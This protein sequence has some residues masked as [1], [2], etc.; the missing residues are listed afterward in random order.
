[1]SYPDSLIPL[2]A[3]LSVRPDTLRLL[4]EMAQEMNATI[5]EVLSAIAED[6]VADLEPPKLGQD[7]VIPFQCSTADL[8]AVQHRAARDSS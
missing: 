2:Q 7:V 1:M 4:V 5:A 6:A 3:T 8:I